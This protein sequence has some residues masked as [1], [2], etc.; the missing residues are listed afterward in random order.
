MYYAIISINMM[1][2]ILYLH[3]N[4]VQCIG[5]TIPTYNRCESS[6]DKRLWFRLPIDNFALSKKKYNPRQSSPKVVFSLS[7][8]DMPPCT[9]W[10]EWWE[11]GLVPEKKIIKIVSIFKMFQLWV[12]FEVFD[13][14]ATISGAHLVNSSNFILLR[15]K[16]TRLI[17]LFIDS[18]PLLE[19]QNWLAPSYH[20]HSLLL[21]QD[22]SRYFAIFSISFCFHDWRSSSPTWLSLIH[23]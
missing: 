19:L 14:W 21:I 10:V 6:I 18:S 9:R 11:K 3:R 12:T 5:S 22:S 17:D 23:F 8:V 20:M 1:K 16:C 7:L 15:S 2:S 13:Q 4:D